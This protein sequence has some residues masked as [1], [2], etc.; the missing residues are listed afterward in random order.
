MFVYEVLSKS[1]RQITHSEPGKI[2]GSFNA[3]FSADGTIVYA[4]RPNSFAKSDIFTINPY[5][6]GKR[7]LTTNPGYEGN[8]QWLP[9]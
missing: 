2:D 8:P 6:T 4:S 9:K 1:L 7:Q 5:G 3:R